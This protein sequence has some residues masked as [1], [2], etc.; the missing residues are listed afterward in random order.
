M[1]KINTNSTI[2]TNISALALN[3]MFIALTLVTT[4][5][6]N[7]KLPITSNGGLIHLGNVPLFIAAILFGRRTGAVAGAF[8]MGLFD[9]LSGWSLWAPFTFIIAGLMGYIIGLI[10][11][12]KSGIFYQCIAMAIVCLIKI[13]GY[14]IAEVIIYHN[15]FSPLA[16]I[17]GNIIQIGLA[18]IIVL[19]IINTLKRG[20]RND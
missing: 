3:G 16:S 20:M 14:Y 18:A 6:I 17:P 9:L 8:G 4:A 1:N 19:P 15:L 12:K 5:Y 2:H 13:F 10:T 11:E 7:V